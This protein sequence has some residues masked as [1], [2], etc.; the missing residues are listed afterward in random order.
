MSEKT[1]ALERLP[2][3]SVLAR[4]H[5]LAIAG[6]WLFEV[7]FALALAH[8]WYGAFRSVYGAHPDG[9]L[10]LFSADGYA[11][12]EL[13]MKTETASRAL[14]GAGTWMIVV[15]MLF[16]QLRTAALVTALAMKRE[17]G[18]P[19]RARDAVARAIG[20]FFRLIAVHVVG[21]IAVAAM[22]GLGFG[23]AGLLHESLLARTIDASADVWSVVAFA[24][25][26]L[27][28]M[29][30]GVVVDFLRVG[31]V[32]TDGGRLA[33]LRAGL[34]AFARRP[35]V[36]IGG[37]AG[38]AALGAALVVVGAKIAGALGGKPGAAVIA[39]FLAHQ[40]VI[41]ARVI[42]R[43]SW[44]AQVARRV[45]SGRGTGTEITAGEGSDTLARTDGPDVPSP[46][47]AA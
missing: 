10:P 46:D 23:L 38:R 16:G 37:W 20:V 45:T 18:L 17:D 22:L 19:L 9:D 14:T 39:L 27:L 28:A 8:P 3:G 31:V 32:V 35:L 6:Y 43:A 34:V 41:L 40:A 26:L 30:V 33:G 25:F 47:P 5:P 21:L 2:S 1:E 36:A 42:L 15:A 29:V 13:F 44:L 11:L 7:L 12:S 24:P 4:K